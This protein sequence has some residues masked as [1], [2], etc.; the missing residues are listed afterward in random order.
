MPTFQTNWPDVPLSSGIVPPASVE[1]PTLSAVQV[2][3]NV[4]EFSESGCSER[5][6]GLMPPTERVAPGSFS[7]V[8]ESVSTNRLTVILV[9][10]MQGGVPNGQIGPQLLQGSHALQPLHVAADVTW[11]GFPSA[12][13]EPHGQVVPPP[14]VQGSHFVVQPAAFRQK[15]IE[16]P[17][18]Q[19][20]HFVVQPAAFWQ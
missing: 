14:Q 6:T 3:V 10:L 12:D 13:I 11:Q 7:V 17:H 9:V 18:A 1:K 19:G 5:Y 8:S 16:P 20:T 4:P 15:Q 2:S